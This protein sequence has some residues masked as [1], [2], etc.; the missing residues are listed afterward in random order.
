MET[1]ILIQSSL[2]IYHHKEFLGVFGE[3]RTLIKFK[4]DGK[5]ILE[6]SPYNIS[7]IATERFK[8]G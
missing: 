5:C 3:L 1:T 8:M 4:D 6:H 2:V 7:H